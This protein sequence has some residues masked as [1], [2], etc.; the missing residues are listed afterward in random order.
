MMGDSS[1]QS[2]RRFTPFPGTI[3]IPSLPS[4][5]LRILA[6]GSHGDEGV[7]AALKAV[8][9]WSREAG[10]EA[11]TASDLPQAV[12][13][14]SSGRWDLVFIGL[15]ERPLEELTWW[16]D[17][18]RA[19][20]G[21]PPV[22]AMI[23]W[24]SMS[25]VHEADKLGVRDV[26]SLPIRREDFSRICTQLRAAVEETALPLP[27]V[28]RETTGRYE[29]IGEHP[30]ML[31]IY[32]LIARVAKSSATVL[33][34]GES[35]TGKECVAREIHASSARATR[36][37][38]AVNCAAI[39]ENLLESVLFG[40]EK[41]AFTGAVT[42]KLGRFEHAAGGTLFLD[43]LADMSLSLQSKIL[44]AVQ[45]REVERVGSSEVI[46]VDVRL[47]G[48]TNKD[49]RAAVE[50]GQF[51]EDLYYRLAVV[52]MRL[53]RL[54]DRGDDLFLLTARFVHEFSE[55]HDKKIERVSSRVLELLFNHDWVGN[56]RE[57]RNVVERAV[58]LADGGTLRAEHLPDEFRADGT[59][60]PNP[61]SNGV[62]TLAEAERRHI[63]LVLAQTAGQ[64]GAAAQALG[65]HRNTLAR[66]MK[67]YGL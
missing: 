17:S 38:V 30:S 13:K 47:I 61:S 34:E 59:V 36:P 32:K 29:L 67:E 62:L 44:R 51:R 19:A 64:I 6:V 39:P 52:T 56:V 22:V 45:E 25:I 46:P 20:E 48:A 35:G 63:A 60:V 66:K 14:L 10:I 18:L 27:P 7:D 54:A 1:Q 37:F 57:L 5:G 16:A 11:E 3:K 21:A 26:L 2:K 42:R 43:E 65:I 28:E 33:I 31:E 40:H 8:E 58:I 49:L 23:E 41:G 9:R 55:R 4:E 12:R 15:G 50:N 24:P 53:P